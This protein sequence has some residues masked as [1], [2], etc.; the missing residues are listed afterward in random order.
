MNFNEK[1][2]QKAAV[3]V[4]LAGLAN[5][6]WGSAASIIKIGYKIFRVDSG[7]LASQVLFAGERF[8]LAGVLTIV[9]GSLVNG[10][11]LVP[12]KTS[13]PKICVLAMFQTI[14]HY[15][16][17]Y[18]GC[19]HATG[20]NV[21]IAV[22]TGSFITILF[23]SLLF[24]QEKL[25]GKK[26]LGCALGF[27]GVAL[28]NISSES[29]LSLNMSLMGEGA[30]IFSCCSYALSSCFTKK[31]SKT[32]NPVMLCGY[33]FVLGGAIMIAGALLLGGRLAYA[34]IG[35]IVL[36]LYLALVS[37]VAF[38]LTSILMKYNPVSRVSIFGFLN[39]IF[40]VILSMLVLGE[41]SQEFGLKGLV[42]LVLVCI[43]VLIV[44]L[45]HKQKS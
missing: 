14:I 29:G 20:T 3:I 10:K 12:T 43:G 18:M 41:S 5:L 4:A 24:R 28:I 36:V 37:A 9:L 16:L 32:E 21:S 40:G 31:F 33:Q 42:A 26:L 15:V 8:F 23:S 38:S 27:T 2:M 25:T 13:G 6:L 44:N 7:D 1:T 34:G 17:F 35:G 45:Q 39:P 22:S 19:A 11:L 30:I